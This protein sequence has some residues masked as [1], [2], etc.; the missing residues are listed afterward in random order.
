MAVLGVFDNV[1]Y[2]SNV[3][4]YIIGVISNWTLVKLFS[5]YFFEI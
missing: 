4:F 1:S 2:V 5:D 3:E